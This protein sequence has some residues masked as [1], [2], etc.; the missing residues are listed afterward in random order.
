MLISW[1]PES[2]SAKTKG[3]KMKM[4]FSETA[5]LAA[6]ILEKKGSSGAVMYQAMIEVARLDGRGAIESQKFDTQQEALDWLRDRIG[7]RESRP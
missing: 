6:Q 7:T 3:P 4:I 1:E 2:A 5:I